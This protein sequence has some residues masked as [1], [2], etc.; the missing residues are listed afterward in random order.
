MDAKVEQDK[1]IFHFVVVRIVEEFQRN[2]KRLRFADVDRPDRRIVSRRKSV[3]E[4]H[5]ALSA[6]LR[7]DRQLQHGSERLIAHDR[8]VK[9]FEVVVERH[10]SAVR[11]PHFGSKRAAG[12]GDRRCGDAENAVFRSRRK[13]LYRIVDDGRK[14]AVAADIVG[15]EFHPF[16]RRF[17]R[18][19]HEVGLGGHRFVVQTVR[20]PDRKRKATQHKRNSKY[21]YFIFHS[22][23]CTEGLLPEGKPIL[24]CERSHEHRR[25]RDHTQGGKTLRLPQD[26]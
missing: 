16:E 19:C 12:R 18:A 23:L 26:T 14:V 11:D 10:V 1:L 25:R 13:V 9:G 6:L 22:S 20:H 21:N 4:P 17:E 8:I 15:R 2:G 24:M 3:Y 7:R 5:F